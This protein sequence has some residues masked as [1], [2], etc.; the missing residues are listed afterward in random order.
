MRLYALAFQSRP[1]KHVEIEMKNKSF[2]LHAPIVLINLSKSIP[3]WLANDLIS[4]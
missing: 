4:S 2:W 1:G 3:I